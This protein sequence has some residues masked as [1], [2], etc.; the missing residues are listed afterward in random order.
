MSRDG[1][2]RSKATSRHGMMC[3][4]FQFCQS[5][6]VT[7][8]DN[9]ANTFGACASSRIPHAQDC[10]FPFLIDGLARWS[11]TKRWRGNRRTNSAAT[12]QLNQ[13]KLYSLFRQTA[14]P[15]WPQSHPRT[16]FGRSLNPFQ[17][18]ASG[19]LRNESGTRRHSCPVRFAELECAIHPVSA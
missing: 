15:T 19:C 3:S 8:P 17:E 16:L 12:D 2:K 9:L 1:P 5:A 13:E 14:N 10:R 18:R 4:G 6:S 11:R 7:S